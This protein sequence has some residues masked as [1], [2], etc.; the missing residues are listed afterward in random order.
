[1]D[2]RQVR[3]LSF[4]NWKG[5]AAIIADAANDGQAYVC[6]ANHFGNRI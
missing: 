1:M 3:N 4:Q 6:D 5:I 2:H